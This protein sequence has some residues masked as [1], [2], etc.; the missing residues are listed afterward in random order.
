MIEWGG[1]EREKKRS[2]CTVYHFVP[3]VPLRVPFGQSTYYVTI[4]SPITRFNR[5]FFLLSPLPFT[6]LL[7]SS[8]AVGAS[9]T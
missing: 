9:G 8:I 5:V 3:R 6:C 4:H 7:S 2:I 1:W